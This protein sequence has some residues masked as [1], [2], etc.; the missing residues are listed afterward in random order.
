MTEPA[1]LAKPLK[2][3]AEEN[4]VALYF[5]PRGGCTAAV[6]AEIEGAKK[7]V[8]VQ[9]YRLT[10]APIAKAIS[11]AHARGL[12]VVVLLDKAAAGPAKY[13]DA[14]YYANHGIHVEVDQLHAIAHN[15]VI[16]VDGE[17][18]ITGSF[19]F[20]KAAEEDNAENLLVLRGMSKLARAY[21][22]NFDRHLSHA[23]PYERAEGPT[24]AADR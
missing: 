18:V 5:S 10:S 4:G 20:S 21:A 1:P 22:E 17:T 11:D 8:Y 9:A 15:K 3:A 14:T 12:E 13:S 6:V 16:I 24:E 23:R 2:P 19:N 7:S